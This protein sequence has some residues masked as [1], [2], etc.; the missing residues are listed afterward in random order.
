MPKRMCTIIIRE[1]I[2]VGIIITAAVG[3]RTEV[4]VI[5]IAEA[6]TTDG[7]I[8]TAFNARLVSV[9]MTEG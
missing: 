6:T 7:A 3:F 5:R 8:G 2:L 9:G 4:T 1:F